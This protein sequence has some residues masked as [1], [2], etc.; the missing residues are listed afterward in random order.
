M[1]K[2]ADYIGVGPLF[3]TATKKDV[4]PAVG[5]E[6][7]DYVVNNIP[8]PFVAIGGIK[9]H[10]IG[11]VAARGAGLICAV[12]EILGAGDIRAK[13]AALGDVRAERARE[14]LD[15]LEN[16]QLAARSRPEKTT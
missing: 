14:I 13:I 16:E 11:A 7:L 15:R 8:L 9:E 12:T 6:Y 5:L 4:C 10:N 1:V 3:P 2:Q